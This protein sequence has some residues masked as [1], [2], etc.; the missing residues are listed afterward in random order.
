VSVR[1]AGRRGDQAQRGQ[2][3]IEFALVFPIMLVL[4]LAMLDFGFAFYA[5]LTVEYASREGA[6]V[7]AALAAGNGS[8]LP[9]S[10]VDNHVIAAVQRVLQ[11]AGIPVQVDPGDPTKGGVQ[12]IR[13]YKATSFADGS[14]YNG[15]YNEWRYSAGGGPTVDGTKL[16]FA[17]NTLGWDACVAN[18]RLNGANPD[19]LGVAIQYQYAWRTPLVSAF[20]LLGG[21]TSFVSNL[22]FVDRTVMNLNPTYP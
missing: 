22:T 15:T 19:A 4:L 18:A 10:Q 14:G 2:G 5:N 21:G 13:I 20:R 9:C 6:R 11:S 3:V 12:W 1:R 8:T 7:G 17:L 16:D